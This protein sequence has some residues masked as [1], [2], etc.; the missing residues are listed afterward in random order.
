MG[1]LN[2][3]LG[4]Y[5]CQHYRAE[6]YFVHILSKVFSKIQNILIFIEWDTICHSIRGQILS[7]T[8][9]VPSV[10]P[11]IINHHPICPIPKI[12]NWV[13]TS[14]PVPMPLEVS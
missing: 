10:D 9:F 8:K 2:T 1:S 14:Q 3:V 5:K 12:R 7:V 13:H 4:S 11:I 6:H